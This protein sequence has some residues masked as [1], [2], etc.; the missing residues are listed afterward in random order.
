MLGFV[1]L[2][3]GQAEADA[4]G[5][6]VGSG[7]RALTATSQHD[8]SNESTLNG[9]EPVGRNA[10]SAKPECKTQA[11]SGMRLNGVQP[12]SFSSSPT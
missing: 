3:G 1:A 2:P 7:G 9:I 10:V 5:E 12:T 4:L 11:Q 6:G 8:E